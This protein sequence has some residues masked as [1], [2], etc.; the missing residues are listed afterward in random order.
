MLEGACQQGEPRACAELSEALRRGEMLPRDESRAERLLDRAAPEAIADCR[1]GL[2]SCYDD[3]TSRVGVVWTTFDGMPARALAGVPPCD[4]ALERVCL[5]ATEVGVARCEHADA[6][7]HEVAELLERMLAVGLG[8]SRNTL[9]QV[10][11]R[12]CRLE[13]ARCADR[14][15]E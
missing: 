11:E 5:N 6:G 12:A 15:V 2:G 13:P 7:C 8:A 4:A 14:A 3:E 9:R 10:N 1:R